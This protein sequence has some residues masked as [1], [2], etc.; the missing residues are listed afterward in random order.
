[1]N[2]LPAT[3]KLKAAS[4]IERKA[5]AT[6]SSKLQELSEFCLIFLIICQ[7]LSETMH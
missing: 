5:V 4:C 6:W 1:M 2:W 7:L 3:D